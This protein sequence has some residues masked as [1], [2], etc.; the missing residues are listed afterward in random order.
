MMWQIEI[1]SLLKWR[2]RLW[3]EVPFPKMGRRVARILQCFGQR[4]V[5]GLQPR[6]WI[7][8]DGFLIWR[9]LFTRR[10]LQNDLRRQAALIDL[11]PDGI[12]VRRMD[13]SITLWGSGAQ[14]LYGWSR[15]E[16]ALR[17]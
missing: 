16:A 6:R 4:A 8:R 13:G 9:S 12:L 1:K 3:P 5:F 17:R 7:G 10:R 14:T 2:I 15:A 11:S